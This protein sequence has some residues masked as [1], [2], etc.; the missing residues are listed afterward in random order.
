MKKTL[1]FTL[2]LVGVIGHAQADSCDPAKTGATNVMNVRIDGKADEIRSTIF[3][4]APG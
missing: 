1:L 4:A 2:C 3:R